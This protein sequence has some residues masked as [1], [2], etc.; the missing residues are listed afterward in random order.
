MINRKMICKS[1]P[2]S[3]NDRPVTCVMVKERAHTAAAARRRDVT[4]GDVVD[5]VRRG[6][7]SRQ[8][9]V[10]RGDLKIGRR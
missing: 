10:G 5:R 2:G 8:S 9:A 7:S 6:D 3:I 1:G 4:S